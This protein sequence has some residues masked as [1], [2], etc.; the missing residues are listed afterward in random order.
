MPRSASIDP[1]VADN[2]RKV[3]QQK[4]RTAYSVA[5][6]MGYSPGWFYRILN[7]DK[8]IM[9]PTLR[10][11]AEELGVPMSSLVDPPTDVIA[12]NP[13]PADQH[14]A[15]SETDEQLV[16][17]LEIAS[18][19]GNGAFVD[20]ERVT[21]RV[22]FRR[23]WLQKQRLNAD[24]CSVIHVV[25]ESMEPTLPDGCSILVNRAQRRRRLNAIFV[26]RTQDGLLVKRAGKNEAGEWLLLSDHPAWE[27]MPWPDGAEVVGEV[28][29]MAR[30]L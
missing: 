15:L 2:L 3:L 19:A 27:P 23:S 9:L 16:N 5:T 1:V 4:G 17:V 10:E 11:V 25:G 7:M 26:I 20:S 29:W 24:Q 6:A 13:T 30:T 12:D 28:R 18:A 21:G 8:G 14:A 22:A